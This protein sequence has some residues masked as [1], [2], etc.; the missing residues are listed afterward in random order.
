MAELDLQEKAMDTLTFGSGLIN[1][2][3]DDEKRVGTKTPNAV[4]W[5]HELTKLKE[6]QK[7]HF[8]FGMFQVCL[9][10]VFCFLL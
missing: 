3:K 4:L 9:I 6:E 1:S 7:I 10:P 8:D 2:V 5:H